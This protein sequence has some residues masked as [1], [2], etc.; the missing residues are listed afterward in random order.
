MDTSRIKLEPSWMQRISVTICSVPRCRRC[1]RSCAPRSSKASAIYPPGPEIFAAFEHTPFDAVRVVILGQDPYHGPGQ[2]HGL[3][4]SV[5]PGRAGA[6]VA[7]QHLQGDPARSRHRAPRPWLPHA[8]GRSRRAA[9]QQ[10][11]DGGRGA[12]WRTSEARAGK[13]SPM[14]PSMRSIASAKAWCSCCGA[15]YAQRKGQL[16]D[17]NGATTV[18]KFGASLAIV[19]PP[20]L[21]RLRALLCGQPGTWK[22]RGQLQ[23]ST[24]RLPARVGALAPLH[25]TLEC[26]PERLPH[27]GR[28]SDLNRWTRAGLYLYYSSL[29]KPGVRS[30]EPIPG[31]TNQ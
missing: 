8:V 25:A 28:D 16:I 13:A 22:R 27:V 7:G 5:R 21:H 19:G 17:R 29:L 26:R 10:R 3:C 9:A 1:P 11:A 23:R 14:R 12:R 4:F 30:L 15:R 6:A 2:A 24:G 20:R 31:G 18:L